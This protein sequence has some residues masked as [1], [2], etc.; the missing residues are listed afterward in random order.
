MKKTN[1]KLNDEICKAFNLEWYQVWVTSPV[2]LDPPVEE[3]QRMLDET[4]V[5][6]EGYR[7]VLY[8]CDGFSVSLLAAQRLWVAKNN[9]DLPWSFFRVLGNRCRGMD[10]SHS[11][12]MVSTQSGI[13]FCE[14]MSGNDRIWKFEGVDRDQIYMAHT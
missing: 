10:I 7:R 1:F 11:W 5:E 3:V 9:Y 6:N 8:D 13:Y 14:S 4:N 2:L 12:N